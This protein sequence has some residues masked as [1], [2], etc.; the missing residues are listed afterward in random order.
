MQATVTVFS[1]D[2]NQAGLY[3]LQ[4]LEKDT[5]ESDAKFETIIDVTLVDFCSTAKI[6]LGETSSVI[7]YVSE[8][9]PQAI[10]MI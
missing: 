9:G 2:K 4:L 8:S 1:E 5:A 10:D 7:D 6:E 3:S